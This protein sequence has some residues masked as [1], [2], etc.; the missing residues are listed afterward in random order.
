M[1]LTKKQEEGLKI[2]VQRYNNREKCTVISGYAGSGKSTLIK[3]IIEA[4]KMINPR[5]TDKDIVYTCFTGKACNVL[6]QKGLKNVKT[7]NK[8]LYESRPKKEGGYTNIPVDSI[9]EKI[10]IVDEVSM[11]PAQLMKLLFSYNAYIICCGDPFQLPPVSKDEDNHL[12]DHPHIFLDEIM[13]QA[14]DSEIIRLSM[15][16]RNYQPI[17]PSDYSKEVLIFNKDDLTDGML[18]WADQILVA[19]NKTRTSI[20]TT[21]RTLAG[22]GEKPENGDKVIC[23]RNYWDERNS[24]GDALVNGTIGQ[25][26]TPSELTVNFPHYIPGLDHYSCPCISGFFVDELGNTYNKSFNIDKQLFNTGENFLTWKDEYNI[27]KRKGG[28][29]LIPYEFTYGYAITTHRAQGSQW[30]K[31]LVV[32]EQFP[33]NREEHARWLYT[34]ITRAASKLVLIRE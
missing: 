2:A 27:C 34:A 18:T 21:M 26:M 30:D 4:L 23:L 25:I 28:K 31:V 16:I 33:H 19:T 17:I 12:L 6:M 22:R 9:T 15:K 32:E 5:L 11:A 29:Y 10:V 24:N 7:L 14:Q 13:R 20:N 3:F 1:Q 8:L